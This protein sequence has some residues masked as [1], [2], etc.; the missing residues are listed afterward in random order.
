MNVRDTIGTGRERNN[1]NGGSFFLTQNEMQSTSMTTPM[2]PRT[3]A[4][5]LRHKMVPLL[6]PVHQRLISMN[7]SQ[8]QGFSPINGSFNNEFVS[9]LDIEREKQKIAHFIHTKE[10]LIQELEKRE[11]SI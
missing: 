3:G 2:A 1:Q 4:S 6:T 9:P 10:R 7:N 8:A 11:L 5:G